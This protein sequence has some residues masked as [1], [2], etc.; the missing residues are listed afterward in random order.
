MKDIAF[1]SSAV[2]V[3]TI[4]IKWANASHDNISPNLQQ[5]LPTEWL[6]IPLTESPDVT[7]RIIRYG[8]YW[9]QCQWPLMSNL[10]LTQHPSMWRGSADSDA[11]NKTDLATDGRGTERPV[12]DCDWSLTNQT[13]FLGIWGRSPQQFTSF[14]ILSRIYES[15]AF[16]C[17]LDTSC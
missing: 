14:F 12:K 11:D 4:M 9:C 13:D 2:H 5:L 15:E 17:L 3:M 1:F 16:C 7:S 8:W 10:N 6:R